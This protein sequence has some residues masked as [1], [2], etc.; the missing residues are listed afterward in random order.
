MS[1]ALPLSLTVISLSLLVGTSV[2]AGTLIY[3]CEVSKGSIAFSDQPC[4]E[5]SQKTIDQ[6]S[7]PAPGTRV[8]APKVFDGADDSKPKPRKRIRRTSSSSKGDE[9][10]CEGRQRRLD[11]IQDELRG[12][13][14]PSRGEQLKRKRR[15][16]EEE[17]R[18]RCR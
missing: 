11:R 4:T 7:A 15:Q 14:S 17:I 5:G 10:W 16:L 13:Y 3:R 12:G 18:E 6:Q 8:V 2:E 9:S 1:S